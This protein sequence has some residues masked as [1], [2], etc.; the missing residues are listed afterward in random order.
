MSVSLES[1]TNK[2]VRPASKDDLK[3]YQEQ[4]RSMHGDTTLPPVVYKGRY[5]PPALLGTRN[6][7]KAKVA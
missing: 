5:L 3:R 7:D 1:N 6:I 4:M 2:G